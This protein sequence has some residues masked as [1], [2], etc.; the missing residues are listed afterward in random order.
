[1]KDYTVEQTMRDLQDVRG[2]SDQVEMRLPYYVYK[3][4]IQLQT[5]N[6]VLESNIITEQEKQKVS[7]QSIEGNIT[8]NRQRSNNY[9]YSCN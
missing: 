3:Q 9:E 1:M 6:K 2:I 7:M 8:S 4:H 5:Q